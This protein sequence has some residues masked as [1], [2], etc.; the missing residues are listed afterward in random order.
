MTRF[1]T[2]LLCL[3]LATA[4][5]HG[6]AQADTLTEQKKF[7]FVQKDGNQRPIILG[8]SYQNGIKNG[9]WRRFDQD[10]QLLAIEPYRNDTISGITVY[11]HYPNPGQVYKEVGWM[12]NSKR[13]SIWVTYEGKNIK[14]TDK[15]V[16]CTVYGGEE[17]ILA[18]FLFHPN[19]SV[20]CEIIM[21][22]AGET[23]WY[24]SF[25]ES[26]NLLFEGAELP[27]YYENK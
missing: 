15:K 9:E 1:N 8:E 7:S 2:G 21:N 5:S 10:G 14:K 22:S 19:G 6:C 17:R 25:N 12:E 3:V 23:C 16:S 26:G 11:F 20:A 13:I 4:L 18:K 27:L 24:R